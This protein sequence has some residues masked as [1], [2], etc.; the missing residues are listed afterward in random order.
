META[1]PLHPESK[2][3]VD[4]IAKLNAKP[5]HELESIEEARARNKLVFTNVAVAGDIKYDGSRKELFVPQPDF[6]GKSQ[7]RG[8]YRVV[9]K[10]KPPSLITSKF[11][12]SLQ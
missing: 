3:L 7:Q 8:E 6:T 4:H 2:A 11:C 5:I 10:R 9:E 12:R 1:Q